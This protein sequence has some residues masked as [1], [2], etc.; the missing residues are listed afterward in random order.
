MGQAT[1]VQEGHSIDYTPGSNVSAG[2]VIV[3]GSVSLAIAKLDIAANALGA[4][5]TGGVFDGVKATGAINFGDPVYWDVD[6]DPVGGTAG[7]GALTTTA[8][9][10][11]YAGRAVKAALSGDAT[12]RFELRQ[13]DVL[14]AGVA[15]AIADPG[16]EG[17]IPV[18]RSGSC[19]LVTEGAETRT[20]AA[21]SFLGQM[22]NLAFKTDGG[23]C[24]ITC[25]TAVN[26][27][28]NNT[29]TLA[30]AGDEI[31]L[32]AGQSGADL[33]WR[34][35]CNDGVALSTV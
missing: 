26:Q 33:R 3:L 9:A 12:V 4:L 29:L 2:Q 5:A 6:G 30:D 7:T 25:A 10:N 31:L 11:L 14:N 1:F 27:T 8:T 17:A 21:P 13:T 34:V 28:G 24:V 18:T 15:N 23:D 19:P 22:L 16:D 35:V 20:L 32:V